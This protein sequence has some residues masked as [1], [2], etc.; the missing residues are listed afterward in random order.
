MQKF[1]VRKGI[2]LVGAAALS[3]VVLVSFQNCSAKFQ[4]MTANQSSQNSGSLGVAPPKVSLSQPSS[5]VANLGTKLQIPVTIS[6][7][8]GYSGTLNLKV[9]PGNL[10]TVDPGQG[11]TFSFS[12][13]SVTLSPDVSGTST[14]TVD[15]T[16]MA[17]SF[18]LSQFQIAAIDSANPQI[19]AVVSVP[20]Q[21]K[22]IFDVLMKGPL[23]PPAASPENWSIA[24]GS[25][26]GFISHPEGLVVRFQNYGPTADIVHSSGGPIPHE[27][28]G[29]F[30]GTNT[31]GVPPSPDGG[32]TSGGA[33]V[34]TV[35]A[36]ATSSASI[37]YS[38]N[39]E[40]GAQGRT[41]KFNVPVTPVAPPKINDPNATFTYISTN[42]LQPKCVACHSAANPAGGFDLSTY[43]GVL[44]VVQKGDHTI[45]PLYVAT[46]P[47]N[48][49]MPLGGAP[50]SASDVQVIADWIDLGAPNN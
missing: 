19:Q 3:T 24:V 11:I 25:V 26:T 35:A 8:N 15:V 49:N 50:L 43:N 36:S 9:S 39:H 44:A 6:G 14:L 2:V 5:Q 33:Y 16:T 10:S 32:K 41:L 30:P 40:G 23:N 48:G 37:V 27:S 28:T 17:P 42:I 46:A 34:N 31:P 47:P 38:H 7:T 20:I 45:S 13:A 1:S 21:V 18:S 12:P 22:A 29:N 4:P